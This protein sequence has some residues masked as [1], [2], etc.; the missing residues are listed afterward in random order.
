MKNDEE[1]TLKNVLNSFGEMYVA[2][3][4]YFKLIPQ[5]HQLPMETKIWLLKNNLNQIFRLNSVL[6][7][8]AT[9]IVEDTNSVSFRRVFP[10]DLYE[11]L[12]QCAQS[13]FPF[14]SDP[15]F[16]KIFLV[17]LIF[18]TSLSTRYQPDGHSIDTKGIFVIQNSFLE[19]FWR[20]L[21]SRC[22]KDD[23][24]IRLFN[25]FVSRLLRSQLVTE[26]LADFIHRTMINEIDQ[27]EAIIKSMW[28]N[29]KN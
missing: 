21:S 2:L 6:I 14:V 1:L 8:H 25:S 4:E 7:I 19:I 5:F 12:C 20:Y 24:A 3:I 28:F 22:S 29:E 9:G 15:I 11:E 17:I 18:S 23:E 26:K 10:A 16:L 13:L 27:L